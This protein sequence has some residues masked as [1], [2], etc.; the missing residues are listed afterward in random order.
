MY[1]KTR[2][3]AEA[4]KLMNVK[5]DA[6]CLTGTQNTYWSDVVEIIATF[7]DFRVVREY[8]DFRFT[9]PYPRTWSAERIRMDLFARLAS[10]EAAYKKHGARFP[11]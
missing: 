2:D 4:V 11:C 7:A 8:P 6:M 10:A 3:H 5:D 1:R 9:I